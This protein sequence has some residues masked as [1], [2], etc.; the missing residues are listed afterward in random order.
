MGEIETKHRP[1][2]HMFGSGAGLRLMR[3]DSDMTEHLLLRLA[4]RGIVTL[5]IHDSYIVPDRNTDKGELMEGMAAT[6]HKFVG[7][8]RYN[9]T[10]Y[11]KSIPQYGGGDGPDVGPFLPSRSA[12][13]SVGPPPI[14]CVVVFSSLSCSSAT[15]LGRMLSPCQSRMFSAGA[16]VL[17]RLV[18]KRPFGT[19]CGD[20]GFVMRM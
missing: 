17:D 7:N 1:I 13:G 2:A 5:P 3:R 19:K 11:L 4:K 6:L 9:P 18:P 12:P 16:V 8:N 20:A 14:G 15:F 10:G